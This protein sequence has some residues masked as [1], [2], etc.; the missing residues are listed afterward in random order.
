MRKQRQA[1]IKENSTKYLAYTFQKCH[2]DES[3][4]KA[5]EVFQTNGDLKTMTTK[6]N[7]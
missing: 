3:Q 7:V 4:R 2:C 1:Q 5:K 6:C